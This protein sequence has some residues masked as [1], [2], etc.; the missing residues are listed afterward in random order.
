MSGGSASFLACFAGFYRFA[1]IKFRLYCSSLFFLSAKLLSCLKKEI[2]GVEL[3]LQPRLSSE[4]QEGL[5][6]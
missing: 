4:A 6:L 2:W 3:A 5:W 1:S